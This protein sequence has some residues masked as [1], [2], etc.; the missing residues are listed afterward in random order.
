MAGQASVARGDLALDLP[1]LNFLW[2]HPT[3]RWTVPPARP[4]DPHDGALTSQRRRF[5]AADHPV[6]DG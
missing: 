2:G 1:A 3:G 6:L 4:E 5:D